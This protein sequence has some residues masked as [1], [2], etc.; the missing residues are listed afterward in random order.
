MSLF[1]AK[2][3]RRASTPTKPG[4]KTHRSDAGYERERLRAAAASAARSQAGRDIASGM[5]KVVNP[6]R[7]AQARESYEFFCRTYFPEVFTLPWSNDHRRVIAQIETAA[8]SGGLSA[9]AMPRGSGKTSLTEKAVEWATLYGYR[10]FPV[11]LG[12]D[13]SAALEL[14]DTIKT[15]LECNDLL[16]E[17]YPEV[18]YPIRCLDGIAHRANGQ[19]FNGKRTH[20]IWTAKDIVL[21]TIP[22][23][24]ASGAVI[25]VAGITARI[26]GM[27][28]TRPGD[29]RSIR[30]DLVIPDDPQTDESAR[31]PSQCIERIR[32]LCGAVL[33]LAGPGKKI[34]GIMPCTVIRPGDMADEILDRHKHPEWQGERTKLI[35]Q[36]PT[37]EGLWDQYK[38]IRSDSLRAGNGG[39]EATEFYRANR[40]AMDAG[41][42][43][44][45]PSRHNPD[46]ISAL[47]HAVN[48]R[49]D[50]GDAAFFAEY[51]NDPLKEKQQT[52]EY[53]T[54]D[55]IAEKLNG[56]PRGKVPR[57]AT[58]LTAFVD[59]QKVA[60]PWMVCA[61]EDDFTGYV[62][63]YGFFPDQRREYLQLSDAKRT[64][65]DVLKTKSLEETIYKGL[66][67]LTTKL[68]G[69]EWAR[70]DG[71]AVRID[72]CLIDAN[73]GDS[74]DVVYKFCRESP[75]AAILVPSHGRYVGAKSRP[76]GEYKPKPG[77]EIGDHW[78]RPV[79]L[80]RRA[81]RYCLF[82]SNHYKTFVAE[83]LAVGIGGRGCLSLFGEDAQTHRLLAD[84]LTA[85]DPVKVTAREMTVTEWGIK[86]QR[87]DNH[88]LDCLVG[89]HVAASMLRVS[90]AERQQPAAPRRKRVKL[91]DIQRQKQM[92]G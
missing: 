60:L 45:W 59:V 76:F 37:N 54:A 15:D 84:H 66:E 27:K 55:Q 2:G 43:V 64:L 71:T 48:L 13:E 34:S 16:L 61:F 9:F 36:W 51:Q 47:Q 80:N 52:S 28:F 3:K 58:K 88:W 68:L 87:P 74:T 6:A 81:V 92:G 78:R 67:Q 56:R 11:L 89:A 63:D 75:H 41:A 24:A 1:A 49:A 4:R 20:I 72:R 32:I 40:E 19:L 69:Q 85:E 21:P 83:R 7:K 70:E 79:P 25:A 8:K 62:V 14:L 12:S 17:D 26:R 86:P 5:P 53:L 30:P 18:C 77:D 31:S 42:E 44:A 33:G 73:W 46:E 38:K 10:E 22:G 82:D 29:G 65:A 50:L 57:E 39:K 91:S 35:Y 23:S 90:L